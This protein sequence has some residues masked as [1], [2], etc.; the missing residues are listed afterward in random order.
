MFRTVMRC[1]AKP[2]QRQATHVPSIGHTNTGVTGQAPGR[3]LK[4]DH[5]DGVSADRVYT[6]E[7]ALLLKKVGGHAFLPEAVLSKRSSMSLD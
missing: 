5:D 1:S 7:A 2:A 4:A 6:T 3:P